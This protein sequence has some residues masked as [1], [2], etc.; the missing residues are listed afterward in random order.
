MDRLNRECRLKPGFVENDSKPPAVIDR[1][2]GKEFSA[3]QDFVHSPR[4]LDRRAARREQLLLRDSVQLLCVGVP[5]RVQVPVR[6]L[7]PS[8]PS[9][10]SS[11]SPRCILRPV[12]SLD[13]EVG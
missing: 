9:L 6:R 12:D 2:I 10:P 1:S 3:G 8:M 7:C 5:N 11:R 4:D 13:L